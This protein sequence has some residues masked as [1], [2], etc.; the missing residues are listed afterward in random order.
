MSG[1]NFKALPNSSSVQLGD[2]DVTFPSKCSSMSLSRFDARK[3][4]GFRDRKR[5]LFKRY[6]L[7]TDDITGAQPTRSLAERFVYESPKRE[8]TTT[9]AGCSV[10]K[11]HA[12]RHFG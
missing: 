1:P 7:Q 6:I 3:E 12:F 8:L 4:S 2:P 11:T 5:L 9:I 10:T